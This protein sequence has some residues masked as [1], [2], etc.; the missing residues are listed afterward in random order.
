MKMYKP[1]PAQPD[2]RRLEV[3]GNF[4]EP[5]PLGVTIRDGGCDYDFDPPKEPARNLGGRPPEDRDKARQFILDALA[6]KN[7]LV[8]RKLCDEYVDR[9]G[10]RGRSG[11]PETT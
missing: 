2:R 4:K 7:D 6:K 10:Q 8:A 1:D 3:T 11:T 9:G 5:P